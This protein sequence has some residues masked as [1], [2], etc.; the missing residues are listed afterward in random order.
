QVV[1]RLHPTSVP[2]AI[3]RIAAT[4]DPSARTSMASSVAASP[5]DSKLS[6]PG[7]N[8]QNAASSITIAGGDDLIRAAITANGT[9]SSA[10]SA[11]ACAGEVNSSPTCCPTSATP[12]AAVSHSSDPGGPDR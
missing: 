4:A 5:S 6:A 12:T 11:P 2:S 1:Y 7:T 10:P 9:V 3:E 8:D